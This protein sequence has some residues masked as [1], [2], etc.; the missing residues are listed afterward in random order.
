MFK[1][2]FH[3]I[4]ILA[5]LF[6]GVFPLQTIAADP[7]T[8]KIESPKDYIKYLEERG[9]IDSEAL[10]IRDQFCELSVKKQEKF[11]SYLNKPEVIS[12]VLKTP[13][14]ANAEKALY[15]GDIVISHKTKSEIVDVNGD[16]NLKGTFAKKNSH[17]HKLYTFK[18]TDV[19]EVKFPGGIP[20]CKF[21]AWVIYQSKGKKKV[22]SVIGGNGNIVNWC[23]FW[24]ITKDSVENYVHDNKAITEIVYKTNCPLAPYDVFS[25]NKHHHVIGFADG[26]K[27]YRFFN[28]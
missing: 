6:T 7:I 4:V 14:E 23:P 25:F 13:V 9:K 28:G 15:G 3:G 26:T 12:K 20:Q 21:T 11:I 18:V 22:T 27:T 10:K 16:P 19:R 1:K 5:I 24:K 8:A 17:G 2:I